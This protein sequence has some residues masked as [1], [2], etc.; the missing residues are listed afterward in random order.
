[1]SGSREVG[2]VEETKDS[3]V[4]GFEARSTLP[5]WGS[6]VVVSLSPTEVSLAG[7]QPAA[8]SEEPS[9]GPCSVPTDITDITRSNTDGR[10]T[11]LRR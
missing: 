10:Y 8:R 5:S 11:V 1:M 4:H 7:P 6:L 2:C 3:E 9:M